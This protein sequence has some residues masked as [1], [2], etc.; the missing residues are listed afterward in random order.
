MA[1]AISNSANR[2]CFASLAM[3]CAVISKA[4]FLITIRI[5]TDFK[6]KAV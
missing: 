1:V 5:T 6:R 4:Q 3:T 2:D